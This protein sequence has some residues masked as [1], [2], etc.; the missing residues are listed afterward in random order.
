[1]R[2]TGPAQPA[3][4]I[5]DVVDVLAKLGVPYA[6]GG[7]FAVSFYGVPRYTDDADAVIWLKDFDPRLAP[8]FLCTFIEAPL[9]VSF[10]FDGF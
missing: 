2:T 9:D 1:M 7:A 4:L 8:R 10:Y 5:L 3:Q 6:L